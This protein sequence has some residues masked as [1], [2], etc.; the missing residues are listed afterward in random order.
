[1]RTRS[2]LLA[3]FLTTIVAFPAAVRAQEP[4][5]LGAVVDTVTPAMSAAKDMAVPFGALV[6]EV[7]DGSP[8]ADGG[9]KAGDVVISVNGAAT[10]DAAAFESA[11]T[12]LGAGSEVELV[13]MRGKESATIKVKLTA[14]PSL[15]AQKKGYVGL[16]L[17]DMTPEQAAALGLTDVP[18]LRVVKPDS[19]GPGASAGVEPDDV[20]VAL[21]G[22]PVKDTQSFVSD[23]GRR[24]PGVVARLEILRQGA[25]KEIAVKLAE[26]PAQADRPPAAAPAML[27]LDTGGH[28]GLI[29]GLTFTPDGNFLVSGGDD[30]VIR[31]WDWRKGETLRTFRGSASPGPEGK[32]YDMALSPDGK[33]LA[34]AGFMA[35]GFGIRDNEVG[36]IRIFDFATGELVALLEG[37]WNAVHAIAF[38]PDGK[39]LVSGSGDNTVIIWDL[40][41]GAGQQ[42][43]LM[44]RL[45]GHQQEIYTV[46]FT[47][48][49]ERV[50]SGSF[51][52]TL[53]L[54]RVSDGKQL[55]LLEGHGEKVRSVAMAMRDPRDRPDSKRAIIASG[56]DDGEIRLW[57][58]TTGKFLRTLGKQ[59]AWVGSL[60]MTRDGTRL[61][62]T[63]GGGPACSTQP[64][65]VWDVATGK[66]VRELRYHDNIVRATAISPDG[67]LAATGGGDNNDIHVWD[68]TTGADVAG[69]EGKPRLLTGTGA[70]GLAAGFSTD[71]RSIAWG[72]KSAFAE[73]NDRGPLEFQLNLPFEGAA[74]GKPERIA[75]LPPAGGEGSKVGSKNP[76][77]G[78]P[79]R[80]TAA[81]PDRKPPPQGEMEKAAGGNFIRAGETHGALTL[82]HRAGGDYGYNA[83]LDV[84][85]GDKVLV[86][87]KRGA[88]DGYRHNSYTFTPDGK[89]IISG[90]GNGVLQ[91]YDLAT[92]TAAAKGGELQESE[93]AKI[94][95]PLIGHE[96]DVWAVTPS[97]DGRFLVSGSDDQT[98]R[99][100]SL[101]T[102]ELIVTLFHGT[103]GE[104]VMW[105]PQ[106][107][108][109][110]SP[111]GGALVGWQINKGP[112][113]AAEYVR[114]QQLRKQLNRPDIVERA[115]I[116]ASA[117]A[118]VKEAG[119]EKVA[120]EDILTRAPP[121]IRA[122]ADAIAN[123]GRTVL[124]V[125]VAKNPLAVRSIDIFV[126]DAKVDAR[127]LPLSREIATGEDGSTLRAFEV[128]LNQG[129]NTLRV[130]A[131]NEVGESE[132][133]I[134]LVTHNGEGSLDKRGTLWLLAVGVNKYPD[135]GNFCGLK[136]DRPCNLNFSVSD[137]KAFAET[138]A[139]KM[140][141]GHERIEQMVLVNGG[142]KDKEP[143][144]ANIEAALNRIAGGAGDRDTTIVFLAGHGENW[145]GGRYHFLPTD[146]KRATPSELGQNVV[147]WETIQGAV[148]RAKG[149]RLIFVDACR[150]GTAHNAKLLSD[151]QT[152]RFVAFAATGPNQDALEFSAERHG[153]FTYMLIDGLNGK[154]VD[155]VRRA[156]TVYRLGTYVNEAV[157]DRTRGRQT[158]EYQSGQ[159]NFILARE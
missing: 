88:T 122:T 94:A 156:V 154:A 91:T 123:G 55:A 124:K 136:H 103:D 27:M 43:Q 99:L 127:V 95:R 104:W 33:R 36:C 117:E 34:I 61:V 105:T 11:F 78:P 69:P 10:T 45:E 73:I 159:G 111:G 120:V 77:E 64:Q 65:I 56:S 42:P 119:L 84:I 146:L 118:A 23:I 141:G 70:P 116:L 135:V 90:G 82:K 25:R 66:R 21:D 1:M 39:R 14:A 31:V 142:D 87:L 5:W 9:L 4:A 62:S 51:D 48:D 112:D 92:V 74:L 100:W 151:A 58:A 37:H 44:H 150:S 2:L 81:L 26:R 102:G 32:I 35:P 13:R 29:K 144:K 121:A 79:G 19:E 50:V 93:L 125:A 83:L 54:W 126:N 76:A 153:A 75:A 67:R 57:D 86:T 101:A 18:G 130:V 7:E 49:S 131:A 143:T 138:M 60:A 12:K 6:R 46:A 71:S 147:D 110:G 80:E 132:P 129:K 109:T 3:A 158:P 134:V 38:S 41:T 152:D 97:P 89:T 108:Y 157:A 20:I 114:G 40:G 68:L 59:E 52:H 30:K 98:V 8:A 139:D 53:R 16:E 137:A 85:E 22:V 113:K 133:A 96:G 106:G 24:R 63:C 148:T 17:Q 155:P 145:A 15:G 107:F 115:I 149:R 28:M 72:H 47:P 128:P 140:K